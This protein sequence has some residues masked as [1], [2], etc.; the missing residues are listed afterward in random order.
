LVFENVAR[1]TSFPAVATAYK[2]ANDNRTLKLNCG[3]NNNQI[4]ERSINEN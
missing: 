4:Y 3:T 2:K 1:A